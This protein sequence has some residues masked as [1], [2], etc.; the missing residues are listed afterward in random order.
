MRLVR[1]IWRFLVGVK[2]ALVLLFMLLFFGLLYAALAAR[3]GASVPS[4]GAL[5]LE[6]AGVIVDQPSEQPPL[7]VLTSGSN[8]VREIRVRDVIQA[9]DAA[10]KD[11]RI[12]AAVLDL[13][14]FQGAG[15]ANLQSIGEGLKRFRTAGKPIYAYA[16]TYTDAGYYL[17]SFA[18]EIWMEPLGGALITG[19]GGTNIYFKGLLDKLAVNVEVF[20]V[21]TYKAAVE[22]FTRS[23]QSPEAKA[24]SQALVDT[25]WSNWKDDVTR[26]RPR[27]QIDA[28][29]RDLPARAAAAN[30]DM[31]KAAV[32]A[33]LVDKLGSRT[34][35]ARR[36]AGLVGQGPDKTSASWSSVPFADYAQSSR[37]SLPSSGPGVGVVYVAGDIVDGEA[38]PGTAGGDTIAELI[39]KALTNKDI[40]ALVLRIDSPG[41]SVMASERIRLALM[42]AKRR[43]LPIVASMG[44][45]AASGGYWVATASDVIFAEPSTI[46]GS[47]GVFAI[48]PS[49]E[50]SLAKAGLAADG[51]KSTPWSGEPDVLRGLSPEVRQLLQLSVEDIYRRFVARVSVA[52]KLPADKVDEIG[53]GRV[54]AG[55]TA[56]QI[57]LVDRFGGLDAAIAEAVRRA[58]FEPGKARTIYV[59]KQPSLPFQLIG[60]LI[61][62]SAPVDGDASASARDPWRALTT[63]GRDALLR[64][65]GDAQAI[66]GGAS[67]QARCLECG[68]ASPYRPVKA[69]GLLNRID[70]LFAEGLK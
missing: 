67:I 54:W 56:R 53:Q 47:I 13:D 48:I 2:D 37:A 18:S 52:R 62:Q 39:D 51:V 34:D 57:G 36:V 40:K 46:T 24:A 61:A 23:G 65:F 31:A 64:A 69:Y 12:K 45:V 26:A 44:P 5:T 41:G 6:L 38:G 43:K 14:R 7:S 25:L 30:G 22:P 33:G 66:M 55:A 20:R 32:A 27:A 8:L 35:F 28:Y 68:A 59:E 49:F 15:Q 11:S 60:D 70:R 10:A 4:G 58:G 1:L 16:A 19:P 29:V 17:A 63:S 3:P 42:E 21:G 50:A 9:L